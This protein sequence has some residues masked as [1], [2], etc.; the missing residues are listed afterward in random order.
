[1]AKDE[2]IHH[3]NDHLDSVDPSSLKRIGFS[4]ARTLSRPFWDFSC[5]SSFLGGASC[6]LLPR[7][8]SSPQLLPSG[9]LPTLSSLGPGLLG[10]SVDS[11]WV[12]KG[13][14]SRLLA[15]SVINERG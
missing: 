3:Y 15:I 5:S 6:C 4:L 8:L 2:K 1:V 14:D 11:P 10:R 13:L 9:L 12:A 7:V